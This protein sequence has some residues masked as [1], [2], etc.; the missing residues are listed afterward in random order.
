MA[1]WSELDLARACRRSR[2]GLASH[3]SPAPQ[4]LPAARVM[5]RGRRQFTTA[6]ASSGGTGGGSSGGTGSTDSNSDPVGAPPPPP[7]ATLIVP[8]NIESCASQGITGGDDCTVS[9]RCFAT[10]RALRRSKLDAPLHSPIRLCARRC[11]G[12]GQHV[13]YMF[14]VHAPAARQPSIH[15]H[16][17][18][19]TQR[20][21]P[22]P[23]LPHTNTTTCARL[24]TAAYLHPPRNCAKP[25]ASAG[26]AAAR[27]RTRLQATVPGA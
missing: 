20:P 1:E 11:V 24:L 16:T 25:R 21:H 2:R 27:P 26:C 3:N 23:L 13:L 4:R 10:L 8:S 5:P 9:A 6:A 22:T 7:A 12:S 18:T 19:H 15:T 14:W 17:H